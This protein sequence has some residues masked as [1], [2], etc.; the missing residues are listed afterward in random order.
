MIYVRDPGVGLSERDRERVF[1]RF[2]RVDGA[3]SRKT[4][5]TG[6]GL[7]LAKAIVEAHGGQIGVDSQLGHGSTF[8]FSL[9]L[10]AELSR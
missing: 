7:F 1:E 5:G 2:Y 3:L 6:L 4:Q 9:P 10:H 8:Y